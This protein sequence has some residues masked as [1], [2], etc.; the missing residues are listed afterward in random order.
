MN[1]PQFIGFI[2]FF[3]IQFPLLFL[4]PNNL[5]WL[6][7]IG[8]TSGFIVQLV[9]VSW[10]G[11]TMGELGFGSVL[12]SQVQLSGSKLAW[13]VLYG[14][15]VTISSVTSGTL[16]ICDYTRF[17]RSPYCGVWSQLAGWLPAW[18]SNIF[19]VL[20]IAA[21]QNRY[22]TQLWNAA[23][24]LIAIQDKSPTSATRAAVFFAGLCMGLSQLALN[25]VGNTFSGG[26]DMSSLLPRWINIRRG[27]ILTALLS[28]AINPWYLLSSATI[29]LSTMSGYTVFLQPFLAIMVAQYFIIQKR[30]LRVADLYMVGGQSLYWYGIGVNWRA[31]VAVSLQVHDRGRNVNAD[32]LIVGR[33]N[34]ASCPRFRVFSKPCHKGQRRSP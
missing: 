21:T 7:A 28:V 14:I 9:L 2:V 12:S 17:A 13:M 6:L 18:L 29:F 20:T 33:R 11:A 3:V 23:G 5:R 19:G 27:Q 15:S 25:I 8:A 31:V 4:S 26:T 30:R 34:G 1:L 22:G 16:S 24:L 32:T 10:A